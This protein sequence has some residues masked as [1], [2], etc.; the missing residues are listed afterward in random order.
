MG[1]IELI[2]IP[3]VVNMQEEATA[4][5]LIPPAGCWAT[6]R[7]HGAPHGRPFRCWPPGWG[8]DG[9]SARRPKPGAQPGNEVEETQGTCGTG[10]AR[11]G[12]AVWYVAW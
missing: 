2:T 6:V 12:S 4:C 7:W 5:D 3:L 10:T 11:T 8:K 9:R 1:L